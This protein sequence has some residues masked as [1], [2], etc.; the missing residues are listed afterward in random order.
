MVQTVIYMYH[1]EVKDG[2]SDHNREAEDK[3]SPEVT[4]LAERNVWFLLKPKVQKNIFKFSEDRRKCLREL[5]A[6]QLWMLK[7]NKDLEHEKRILK[8]FLYLTVHF[9]V[10]SFYIK[11]L[12]RDIS[13]CVFSVPFC[14]F[15][16][17]EK[18]NISQQNIFIIFHK[19]YNL[20]SFSLSKLLLA[21]ASD[22]LFFLSQMKLPS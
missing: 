20:P 21:I 16:L 5:D 8:G 4:L 9:I 10:F 12:K 14:Q 18:F 7:H 6:K 2:P 22:R 11:L 3:Q 17:L 13:M 15:S 19:C 1:A